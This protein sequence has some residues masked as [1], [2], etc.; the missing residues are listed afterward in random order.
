MPTNSRGAGARPSRRACAF[1]GC[2][3][4]FIPRRAK[5]RFCERAC[6]EAFERA[7]P[8][9]PPRAIPSLAE[10]HGEK[11]EGGTRFWHRVLDVIHHYQLGALG[12]GRYRRCATIT[13][14]QWVRLFCRRS[15]SATAERAYERWKVQ[16]RG[17]GLLREEDRLEPAVHLIVDR[18]YDAA[19]A[20]LGAPHPGGAAAEAELL[21]RRAL[22][23]RLAE[24]L[25]EL[26]RK[27][28]APAE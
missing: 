21:E 24:L 16:A 25:R 15:R 22:L 10:A 5:Q 8:A 9:V 26:A 23:E 4:R 7:L 18:C 14:A 28:N 12:Q 20:V 6:R 17:L 11:D 1:D 19:F 27:R 2:G 3:R 13:K